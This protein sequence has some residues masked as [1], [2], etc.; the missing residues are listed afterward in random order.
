MIH[1]EL[2]HESTK[3]SPVVSC[4]EYDNELTGTKEGSQV[5]IS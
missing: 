5:V 3:Y 2:E 1:K 4:C